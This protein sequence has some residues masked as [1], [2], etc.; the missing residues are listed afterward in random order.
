LGGGGFFT[1]PDKNPRHTQTKG[2]AIAPP[3]VSTPIESVPLRTSAA[4]S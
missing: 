4:G 3:F 2:G 1:A